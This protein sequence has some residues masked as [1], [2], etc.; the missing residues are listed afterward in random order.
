MNEIKTSLVLLVLSTMIFTSCGQKTPAKEAH[1]T[2]DV[3]DDFETIKLNN[4]EKWK[5]VNEMIS[6]VHLMDKSVAEFQTLED[7]NYAVLAKNLQTNVDSLISNC[8]MTG[9][10]HIELHKWLIPYI[11]L[12]D[13]LSNAPNN[14]EAEETN[15]SIQT[16]LDTFKM[17]FE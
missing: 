8:T 5:V 15:E 16:S 1:E 4:G 9:E 13:D 2:T 6:Y 3:N 17:Y 10:G 11:Q 12:L 7:K 14:S